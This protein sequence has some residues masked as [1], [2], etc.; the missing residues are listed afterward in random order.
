MTQSILQFLCEG[1]LPLIRK[2][3]VT[4]IHGLE[5]YVKVGEVE[6]GGEFPLLGTI[7]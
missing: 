5:A 1:Y 6:G 3:S 4:H 2:D 7:L